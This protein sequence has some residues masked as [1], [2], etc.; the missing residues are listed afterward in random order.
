MA[1]VTPTV[2]NIDDKSKWEYYAGGT[3]R[4]VDIN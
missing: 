2:A 1:R 4:V 3:V